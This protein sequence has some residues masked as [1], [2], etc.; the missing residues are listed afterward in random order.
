[1]LKVMYVN[2]YITM[3]AFDQFCELLLQFIIRFL[4]IYKKRRQYKSK[5][6]KFSHGGFL[7]E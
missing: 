6:E 5:E 7:S 4:S 3:K 1:M 2:A